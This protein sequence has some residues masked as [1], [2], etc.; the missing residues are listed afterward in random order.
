VV[1]IQSRLLEVELG[2]ADIPVW[3]SRNGSYSCAETWESLRGMN[4][5]VTWWKL[6]WFSL[7]IS[8][9]SFR[10]WLVFQDAIVTKDRMC[11][12]GYTGDSECLFCHGW[13]ES[14]EHLFFHWSFSRR[15]WRDLMAACSCFDSPLE[16]D[17]VADWGGAVL[18]GKSLKS[19][20]GRLCFG[21]VVY[22]LWKQRNDL[23]HGN[24]PRTEEAIVA[25][26][27][28]EV[29]SRIL[30]KGNVKIIDKQLDLVYSWN[31]QLLL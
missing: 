2:G 23:L 20:L 3:N 17:R 5:V 6:V 12:W 28:W 26:I 16:W 8:R 7:A 18:H 1:E 21:A 22:H 13:Q 15:I 29:R 30:A 9:H 4:P 19:S 24:A 27:K 14:R 31:L 25:H 11:K 10:L